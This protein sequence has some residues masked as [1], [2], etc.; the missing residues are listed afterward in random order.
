MA[1]T[2]YKWSNYENLNCLII[3]LCLERLSQIKTSYSIEIGF[4][5]IQ[6]DRKV[7]W[8]DFT[9]ALNKTTI[10]MTFHSYIG[11]TSQKSS[12]FPIL[13]LCEVPTSSENLNDTL[14]PATNWWR[15]NQAP[16]LSEQAKSVINTMWALNVNTEGS[17]IK[18]ERHFRKE[19]VI[20]S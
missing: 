6:R 18:Q 10:F 3:T 13:L 2:Y 14:K 19:S 11:T 20:S 9:F 8:S 15:W 16:P 17:W 4:S 12:S 7:R 5:E 1:E